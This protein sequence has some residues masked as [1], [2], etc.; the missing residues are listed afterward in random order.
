MKIL[1][2][3]LILAVGLADFT[4]VSNFTK[5][6]WFGKWNIT[7][8][9]ISDDWNHF[10]ALHCWSMQIFTQQ[11][12]LIQNGI[13]YDGWQRSWVDNVYQFNFFEKDEP[14]IIVDNT[15]QQHVVVYWSVEGNVKQFVLAS[16][17][18]TY[19]SFTGYSR[20]N[21][22]FNMTSTIEKYGFKVQPGVN[23]FTI[24]N[25]CKGLPPPAEEDGEDFFV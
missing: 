1:I 4:P 23:Y 19:T 13:Y 18:G 10:A 11:T 15:G 6:D 16:T 14:A 5:G 8:V 2:L 12:M 20:G 17:D 9:F 25:A 22:T 24:D 21:N 3:A 7:G